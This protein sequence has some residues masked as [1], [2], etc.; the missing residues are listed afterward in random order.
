MTREWGHRREWTDKVSG[1]RG[2]TVEKCTVEARELRN[3]ATQELINTGTWEHRTN[4]VTNIEGVRNRSSCLSQE[5]SYKHS[6]N[7]R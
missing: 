4:I 2:G 1:G 7:K 6:L 3:T 5:C